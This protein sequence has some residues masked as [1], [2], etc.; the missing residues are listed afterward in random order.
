MKQQDLAARLARR[1]RTSKAVAADRLDR[2]VHKIIAEL[3]KGNPVSLPGLGTF[4][5]GKKLNFKFEKSRAPDLALTGNPQLT[6][7]PFV[8]ERGPSARGARP[9]RQG[10]REKKH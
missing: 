6:A 8:T 7:S 3:K 1:A 10:L 5:P 4:K 2:I 9:P